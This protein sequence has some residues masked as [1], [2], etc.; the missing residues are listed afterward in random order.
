MSIGS[1]LIAFLSNLEGIRKVNME[2]LKV[3]RELSSA[4]GCDIMFGVNVESGVITLIGEEGR[5]AGR[6]IQGIIVRELCER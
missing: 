3:G 1:G 4:K 5:Y 2:L 6:C